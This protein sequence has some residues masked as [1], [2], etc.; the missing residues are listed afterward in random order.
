VRSGVRIQKSEAR[1]NK[2]EGRKMNDEGEGWELRVGKGEVASACWA[3]F[4][5]YSLH[6]GLLT[7]VCE[8]VGLGDHGGRSKT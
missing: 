6:F 7:F 8:T 4:R 3:W 2:L 1:T 5:P